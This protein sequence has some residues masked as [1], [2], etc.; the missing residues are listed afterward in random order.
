MTP[1]LLM[2]K[3]TG[4]ESDMRTPGT[5]QGKAFPTDRE[6]RVAPGALARKCLPT[7]G[8]SVMHFR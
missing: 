4:V 3:I 2:F 8:S 7:P 1:F 6:A 5:S